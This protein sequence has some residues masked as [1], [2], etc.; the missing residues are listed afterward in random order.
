ME[1]NWTLPQQKKKTADFSFRRWITARLFQ[2]QIDISIQLS[3]FYIP[4]DWNERRADSGG[5]CGTGETPQAL[6]APRRLAARPAESEAPGMERN[7]T[8]PQQK[9]K[10]ADFSFRRWITARLFQFQIDIS[11]QLSSFYIPVDW[12]GRRA[13]SGGSCGTDETPQALFAPR[14]LAARP[15]ESEAPGMERKNYPFTHKLKR[16]RTALIFVDFS[17]SLQPEF[18]GF[19]S[20]F[21][22]RADPL[23]PFFSGNIQGTGK[24]AAPSSY[25]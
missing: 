9:K 17:C 1:R 25:T 21:H 20:P 15:A 18:S 5:S 14:R 23:L 24:S 8:L 11:I 3:S 19:L 6:F 22:V 7:W 10:T 4:V 16:Q 12:N 13:D 2:F